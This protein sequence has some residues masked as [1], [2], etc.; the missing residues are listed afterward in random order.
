MGAQSQS[1]RP[2]HSKVGRSKP[3]S[4][5]QPARQKKACGWW[6][7]RNKWWIFL[8]LLSRTCAISK[9]GGCPKMRNRVWLA[10]E[11]ETS[12]ISIPSSVVISLR[13]VALC[14]VVTIKLFEAA[15]SI[16]LKLTQVASISGRWAKREDQRIPSFLWCS[17]IGILFRVRT[18]GDFPYRR[19]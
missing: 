11:N 5:D 6:T 18:S 15:F 3:S 2:P 12:C 4:P 1:S 13:R 19:T 7:L 16:R 9:L 14:L 17:R 8:V 10:I